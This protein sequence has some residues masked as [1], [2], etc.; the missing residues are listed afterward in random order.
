[1]TVRKKPLNA[2][3]LEV[4]AW[5]RDGAPEGVYDDFGH[6]VVARALHNRG[7]ITIAG[8]GPS[9]QAQIRDDGIHY[10]QHGR[11]PDDPQA[12]TPPAEDR[13]SAGSSPT[14]PLARPPEPPAPAR[15]K[16]KPARVGPTDAMINALTS[17]EENRF[18]IDL[19]ECD[20][21]RQLIGVAKR[22]KKIPDGMQ[23]TVGHDY[24][25]RSAWVAL[26]PLPEWMTKYLDPIP[27]SASL[28]KPTDVVTAIRERDDVDIR[29]AART[30]CLRLINALVVEA[31]TR[32]CT[33]AAVSQPKRDRWGY[34]YRNDETTGHL[35]IKLG[36][37]AYRL[38]FAQETER[39]EH[40]RSKSELARAG[41]GYAVPKW[42]TRRTDKLSIRIDGDG[43]T[44]WGS[45]WTDTTE[46]SLDE[47][48]PQILQEL[49]LRH[50]HAEEQRLDEERLRQQRKQEWERA[51]DDAIVALTVSH[52]AEIL[53]GQVTDWK[54][55]AE[56]RTYADTIENHTQDHGSEQQTRI[57][58]WANWARAYADH[59]DPLHHDLHLPE[60]PDPTPTALEPFMKHLSPYGPR[61]W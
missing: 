51:R 32:G 30:R 28:R 27:V 15:P 16:K 54:M 47:A 1:M 9:W 19:A 52:R 35:T 55:A 10:L 18:E 42:D 5:V 25:T 48:L 26:Q 37:D 58:E 8:H 50:E 49:E 3:Q 45:T 39:T 7:L 23:V 60:P 6:R 21:Y 38:T 24:Q 4:L 12:K 36:H 2:I 40:V 34:S 13:S 57:A 44:F 53:T 59:I 43:R 33:V 56:I 20:R 11:Y 29:G 46:T 14:E 61:H 31:R 17:A 41:R 22:F